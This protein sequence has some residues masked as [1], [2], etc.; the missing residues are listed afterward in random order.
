MVR[1]LAESRRLASPMVA[2]LAAWPGLARI[3][4]RATRIGD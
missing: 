1:G 2:L 4:A 3:A